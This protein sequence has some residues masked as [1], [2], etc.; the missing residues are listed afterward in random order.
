MKES[1]LRHIARLVVATR[2]RQWE[3]PLSNLSPS[4]TW[5][6]RAA[7]NFGGSENGAKLTEGTRET[8]T[9][10][11]S[12]ERGAVRARC[13]SREVRQQLFENSH[14]AVGVRDG[15]GAASVRVG[16]ANQLRK[17]K[18]HFAPSFIYPPP[19]SGHRIS[20]DIHQHMLNFLLFSSS[21]KRNGEHLLAK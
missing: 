18:S 17:L 20:Q 14:Q 12:I 19:T 21:E 4:Q 7:G 6:C 15:A 5:N 3:I 1:H 9:T 16:A 8:N 2:M 11:F 10:A 13:C